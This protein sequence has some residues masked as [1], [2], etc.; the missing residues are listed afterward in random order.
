MAEQ[1]AENILR[2]IANNLE[3][4]FNSKRRQTGFVLVTFELGKKWDDVNKPVVNYISNE[5]MDATKAAMKNLMESLGFI[6]MVKAT[7]ADLKKLS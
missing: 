5:H 1:D 6:V 3:K 7:P 4:G 2:T